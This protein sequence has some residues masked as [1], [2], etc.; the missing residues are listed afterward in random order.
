MLL[1]RANLDRPLHSCAAYSPLHW[2]HSASERR[3]NVQLVDGMSK[4][5]GRLHER[6]QAWALNKVA[7]HDDPSSHNGQSLA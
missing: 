1:G 2:N 7:S 6:R 3:P 4:V 5:S